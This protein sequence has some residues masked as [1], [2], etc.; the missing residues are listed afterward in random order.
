MKFGKKHLCIVLVLMSVAFGSFAETDTSAKKEVMQINSISKYSG[1]YVFMTEEIQYV[2]FGGWPFSPA[3]DYQYDSSESD[4]TAVFT[5]KL[6]DNLAEMTQ[7][8]VYLI[9]S[10]HKNEKVCSEAET[11]PKLKL[12]IIPWKTTTA[13]YEQ[14]VDCQYARVM[15]NVAHTP[16]GC[17]ILPHKNY[18]KKNKFELTLNGDQY[19][20]TSPELLKFL[21]QNYQG[22]DYFS[23]NVQV[24]LDSKC[25]QDVKGMLYFSGAAM[26]FI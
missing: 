7:A 15:Y 6:P 10:T 19:S 13:D 11:V 18:P 3:N 9:P 20:T 1:L 14:W 12:T 26:L 23:I 22:G 25:N 8:G 4:I 2:K 16:Q 5:F 21:Q 24:V 17:T